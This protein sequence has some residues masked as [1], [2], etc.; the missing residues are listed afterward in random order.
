[1]INI[2]KYKKFINEE[3]TIINPIIHFLGSPLF[4]FEQGLID[5]IGFLLNIQ[6]NFIFNRISENG[7][8]RF[9]IKIYSHSERIYP[10]IE[11]DW[12]FFISK[13]LEIFC[14]NLLKNYDFIT[15]YYQEGKSNEWLVLITK[16][17]DLRETVFD[18]F[19]NYRFDKERYD[20]PLSE[21]EEEL[22]KLYTEN[23][24]VFKL[25]N[26]EPKL[27]K[28]LNLENLRK[29]ISGLLKEYSKYVDDIK[30]IE[31]NLKREKK[32]IER[33]L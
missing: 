16:L 4:E 11:D 5:D 28:N 15:D 3:S 20:F 25:F 6:D 23:P 2:L 19:R 29:K 30:E 1:M 9:N 27:I 24:E 22:I 32:F 12:D 31:N 17:S 26:A 21:R 10:H 33:F 7:S 13:K 18:L 14:S 8:I